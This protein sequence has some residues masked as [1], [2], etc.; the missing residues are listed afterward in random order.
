MKRSCSNLTRER[1]CDVGRYAATSRASAVN[2]GHT[3]R[4]ANN[5][6]SDFG[7]GLRADTGRDCAGYSDSPA[8]LAKSL[9]RGPGKFVSKVRHFTAARAASP[10]VLT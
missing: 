1:F 5:Q 8:E 9:G 2:L 10:T 6:R 4:K 7:D 3:R